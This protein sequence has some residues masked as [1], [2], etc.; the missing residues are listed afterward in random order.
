MTIDYCLPFVLKT[1]VYRLLSSV[2]MQLSTS[3]IDR[4]VHFVFTPQHTLS[5][6]YY[7]VSLH[8]VKYHTLL[9]YLLRDEN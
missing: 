8:S 5:V 4:G 9:L 7:Y 3:T 1:I 6:S 2:Y